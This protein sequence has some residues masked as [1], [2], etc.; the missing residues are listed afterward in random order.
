MRRLLA[1]LVA[2]VVAAAFFFEAAAAQTTTTKATTTA[3]ATPTATPV[4]TMP[5]LV[6][7]PVC[8]NGGLDEDGDCI[9][10]SGFDH[11]C[12]CGE[13]VGCNDNAPGI[14]N[15][16]QRD[17]DCDG[18]GTAADGCPNIFNPDATDSDG[19]GVEDACDCE[20]HDPFVPVNLR[21][22][23]PEERH[24]N[25]VLIW[26]LIALG[27]CVILAFVALAFF[28]SSQSLRESPTRRSG[29]RTPLLPQATL[30]GSEATLG[31]TTLLQQRYMLPF[32]RT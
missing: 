19:D 21:C 9:C 17:D 27:A 3:K 20:P 32:R 14:P 31:T 1:V 29:G 23:F 8:E 22:P 11:A 26:L 24:G 7:P 16:A 12:R 13:R 25:S 5:P 10:D 30:A 4:P 6:C 18:R 15:A 28:A 2:V